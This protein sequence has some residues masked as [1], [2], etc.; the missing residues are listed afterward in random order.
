MLYVNCHALLSSERHKQCY[1]KT[2]SW[3]PLIHYIL[4]LFIFASKGCF[5][6]ILFVT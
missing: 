1:P 3:N 2:V 5:G 4:L 6:D